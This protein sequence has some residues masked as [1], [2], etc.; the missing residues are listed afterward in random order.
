MS[1]DEISNAKKKWEEGT[2]AKHQ[3]KHPERRDEYVTTSSKPIQ[4]IY[5]PL[6]V[7]DFD[8]MKD[9]GYPSEYPYTRGP[10]P[11]MYR[12]RI[13]TMRQFAG[14]GNAEET[15]KRFK[16]LLANGQT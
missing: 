6:D 7:P 10:Q 13:W 16:F 15:N 1:H 2:L 9:L 12:G 5:T 14:M 11:T 8:Y 4:R 3:A